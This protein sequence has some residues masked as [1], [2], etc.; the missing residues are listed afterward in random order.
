MAQDSLQ[1]RVNERKIY[2]SLVDTIVDTVYK[3][4]D[5]DQEARLR[6]Y[7]MIAE[8]FQGMVNALRYPSKGIIEEIN[9]EPAEE[10]A[11]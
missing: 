9:E 7:E 3:E 2:E 1:Q 4:Y 11:F 6:I 5:K 8:N 10:E